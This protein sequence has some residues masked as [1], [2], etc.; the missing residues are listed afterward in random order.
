M[1]HHTKADLTVIRGMADGLKHVHTAF[2]EISKLN[3]RYEDDLGHGDLSHAIGEFADNWDKSR[4]ELMGEV[5]TMAKIAK[6]AA[7][8]YDDIDKQ[9]AKALREAKE[10][11]KSHKSG[12]GK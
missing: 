12:K 6:A 9:L 10:P 11:K 4:E 3:E 8:A 7:E 2:K 1:G 5:D